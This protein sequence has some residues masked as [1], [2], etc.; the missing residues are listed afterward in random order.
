ML[1]AG[2]EE[3]LS[4]PGAKLFYLDPSR[5]QAKDTAWG[6]LKTMVPESWLSTYEG[7]LALYFRNSLKLNLAGADY[8]DGL[9][10]QAANLILCDEFAYVSDLQEM[11]EGALLPILGTTK[12]R[13]VFCSTPAG[14]GNFAS[15]L[16][17]RAQ[18][19]RLGMVQFPQR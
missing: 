2:I 6:D 15:E 14:G 12:G 7:Q 13:V 4:T 1:T 11:W 9:R 3:C 16:W 10:G 17:E 18:H 19:P 5:K 8:A